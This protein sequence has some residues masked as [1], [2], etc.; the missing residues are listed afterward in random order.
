[1]LRGQERSGS[2]LVSCVIRNG[3]LHFLTV[4]DSRIYLY[5]GG[6]LIQLNREHIYQEELACRA[7][8]QE[9]SLPQVRGDRQAH[10][11]TSYFGIGRIPYIDR[12]DEGLKLLSGDKILMASDGVFGTLTQAQMEAALT[13]DVSAAARTMGELIRQANRPHQD[14]NTAVVLEYRI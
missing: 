9:V 6:A 8:N 13:Q 3:Y 1:M 12:N 10:A 2:T 5:R 4:G 14:N 11:L 7:V